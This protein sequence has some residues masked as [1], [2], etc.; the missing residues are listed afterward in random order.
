MTAASVSINQVYYV[1]FLKYFSRNR[2]YAN[3]IVFSVNFTRKII[4]LKKSPPTGFQVIRV[5]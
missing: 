5:F 4:P 1:K 2:T 3:L